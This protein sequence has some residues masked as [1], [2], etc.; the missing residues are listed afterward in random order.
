LLI[1]VTVDHDQTVEA[2]AHH[3]ERYARAAGD[4]SLTADGYAGGQQRRGDGVAITRDV[5][6]AVDRY[7]QRGFGGL[8]GGDVRQPFV[9]ANAPS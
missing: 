6:L 7:C 5:R 2:D 9:H 4:G 3:A 1:G 8:S